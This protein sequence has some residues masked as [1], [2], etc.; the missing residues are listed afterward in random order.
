[1]RVQSKRL[2]YLVSP[3]RV[4]ENTR[5]T[6]WFMEYSL[7][8]FRQGRRRRRAVRDPAVPADRRRIAVYGTGE[9][10]ELAYLSITELGLELVGV[11]GTPRSGPFLGHRVRPIERHEEVPFEL[12]LIASLERA[13]SLV[14]QLVGLGIARE[15]LVML[16]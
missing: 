15:R 3:T 14:E 9:A 4:A 7:S 10:A 2:R 12:L 11:F 6:Y 8:L 1:L 5:L 16:R 13:D